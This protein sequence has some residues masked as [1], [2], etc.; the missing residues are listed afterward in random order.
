LLLLRV[1][2]GQSWFEP[3]DVEV[4]EDEVVV[5]DE[6]EDVVDVCEVVD[7]DEADVVE[8]IV[9]VV[10]VEVEPATTASPIPAPALPLFTQDMEAE[11]RVDDTTS[12]SVP[13]TWGFAKWEIR[14]NPPVVV[15]LPSPPF[16]P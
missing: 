12:Y 3:V 13:I 9:V 6:D 2:D 5:E 15:T 7:D 14:V 1:N 4:A 11:D 8:A 16:V 10:D